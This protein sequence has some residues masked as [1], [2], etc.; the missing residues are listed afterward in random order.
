M[1]GRG[2]KHRRCGRSRRRPRVPRHV[3]S[4][5]RSPIVAYSDGRVSRTRSADI[6]IVSA[7]PVGLVAALRPR[8]SVGTVRPVGRSPRSRANRF[9]PGRRRLRCSRNSVS[10]LALQMLESFTS[11]APAHGKAPER[12]AAGSSVRP[13]R[14]PPSRA[15]DPRP[16]DALSERRHLNVPPTPG[17]SAF[18]VSSGRGRRPGDP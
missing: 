13:R 12:R 6:C 4:A 15:G 9:A 8:S 17:R 14:T 1:I 3:R 2:R 16:A 18:R 7:G 11:A 5:R 10:I